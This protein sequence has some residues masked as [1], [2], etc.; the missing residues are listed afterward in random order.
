MQALPHDFA[1]RIYRLLGS[2]MISSFEW[3][4]LNLTQGPH[5]TARAAHT[6]PCHRGLL[7]APLDIACSRLLSTP[8]SNRVPGVADE[9]ISLGYH[10]VW[11]FE[12]VAPNS[13]RFYQLRKRSSECFDGQPAIVSARFNYLE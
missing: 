10:L 9:L 8:A 1:Q 6:P 5:T 12:K 11:L 7:T 3:G 13:S 2:V 4:D